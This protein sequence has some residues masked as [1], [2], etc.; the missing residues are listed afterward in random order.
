MTLVTGL[1]K[2]A[3][4]HRLV[5][6]WLRFGHTRLVIAWSVTILGHNFDITHHCLSRDWSC[7]FS[8][9]DCMV[10]HSPVTKV[11]PSCDQDIL[12]HS[13]AIVTYVQCCDQLFHCSA[14]PPIVSF[15]CCICGGG[16]DRS[17]LFFA[18]AALVLCHIS[19]HG[20]GGEDIFI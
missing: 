16:I 13:L 14:S 2:Y 10:G 5:I 9:Y 17:Q 19:L 6:I 1:V 15:C 20:Y 12:G 3:F 7:V 8:I 4:G 18:A 11:I